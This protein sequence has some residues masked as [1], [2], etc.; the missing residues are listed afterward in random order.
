PYVEETMAD[1]ARRRSERDGVRVIRA[2]GSEQ[3]YPYQ[4]FASNA[5][6]AA[7]PDLPSDSEG[8]RWVQQH[9]EAL[10]RLIEGLV[11][12][13]AAEMDKFTRGEQAAAG[14]DTFAQ[15]VYR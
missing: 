11:N 8:L 1:G 5:P 10:L 13:D 7:P 14:A 15:I 6:P 3:F 4:Y 12:R 2:D 9:N